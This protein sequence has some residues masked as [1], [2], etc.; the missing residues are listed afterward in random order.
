MIKRTLLAAAIFSALPAYAG[1]T[2]ITAGYDFTDY[3]GDHG[4]RNLA[5]A[6]LVA[7]VE[8][9]T[10]LFNLS[11]GRRDYETENFNATRDIN[12]ALLPKT[13][14]T[15][16][17]RY[18]KYYDDVEVDAWQGGVSLYTGPVI[19]SYRYTHY[20]SSDAGGSYS[21]MI[22]VRLNDPRGTGY[23]QLWLSRGTGA[24][25]YDWTPETRYGSMKSV[26]LQ[27]IQPLTE[28][29]NLGLTAGKVWYDTPTD[30]YNG[31]QLAA[32]LTW[33]F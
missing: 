27:R 24:Y 4:N 28:Q 8:N 33:K 21:N 11:Q 32:H 30:D 1:L 19:T 6:E 9:A 23:T 5:Y 10:L 20:D 13:L 26:S 7:K 16:G 22:S 18:T 3:S 2:S 17:Y 14:F 29:L 25:T 31:L 15:T 12:L